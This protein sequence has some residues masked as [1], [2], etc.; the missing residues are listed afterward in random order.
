MTVWRPEP[1]VPILPLVLGLT[2]GLANS[3]ILAG[4]AILGHGNEVTLGL[5]LRVGA[6]VFV[7]AAFSVF[8]AD[9]A[10]RRQRLLQVGRHLHAGR[11]PR[12]AETDLG[13]RAI[14][15]SLRAMT[16]ASLASLVGSSLPLMLGTLLPRSAWI[17][18]A[19]AVGAM[20]ALGAILGVLLDGNVVRW[21]LALGASG[22][23]VS[24]I[25]IELRI[26]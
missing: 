7:T 5:A 2:D 11:R 9:Y 1:R 19:L 23:V 10:E 17:V 22:I 25:G 16:V 26:T 15:E 18:F 13:R 8:V 20:T 4:A 14:R 3:L 24:A 21:A 6:V 12:L